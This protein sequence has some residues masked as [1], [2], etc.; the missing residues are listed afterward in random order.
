MY[1][2][3]VAVFVL[4]VWSGFVPSVCAVDVIIDSVDK[5]K[6]DPT[7]YQVVITGKL[8]K[9]TDIGGGYEKWGSLETWVEQPGTKLT[10][11]SI[12]YVIP[13]TLK[14]DGKFQVSVNV[15]VNPNNA[16]WEAWARATVLLN[17]NNPPDVAQKQ[18]KKA[19]TLP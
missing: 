18:A 19:F 13:P 12:I 2:F 7:T 11:T 3:I 9:L 16:N 4:T 17:N 10:T 14:A 5:K 1:R 15:I 6:L 8:P